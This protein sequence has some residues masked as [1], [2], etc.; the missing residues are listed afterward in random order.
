M[1]TDNIAPTAPARTHADSMPRPLKWAE[2][3]GCT[4]LRASDPPR[5]R[6][7]TGHIGREENEEENEEEEVEQEEDE[8]EEEKEG[9]EEVYNTE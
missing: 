2:R 6:G 5:A 1:R 4:M 7:R 8:E 9:E 3:A